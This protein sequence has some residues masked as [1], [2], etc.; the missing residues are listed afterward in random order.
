MLGFLFSQLPKYKARSFK[1]TADFELLIG[2]NLA[3][4]LYIWI[5]FPAK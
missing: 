4:L 3:G 5:F 2:V 1:I